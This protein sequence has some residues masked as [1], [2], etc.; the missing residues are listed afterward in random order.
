VAILS[1]SAKDDLSQV[2]VMIDCSF[3]AYRLLVD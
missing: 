1:T 3:V 2:P